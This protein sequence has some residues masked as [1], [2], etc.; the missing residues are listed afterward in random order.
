MEKHASFISTLIVASVIS[1][2][3]LAQGT[4]GFQGGRIPSEI[5]LG[6]PLNLSDPLVRQAFQ[7]SNIEYGQGSSQVF[8]SYVPKDK[9]ELGDDATV[10]Y[11][12]VVEKGIVKGTVMTINIANRPYREKLKIAANLF[13]LHVTLYRG[14]YG[15]VPPVEILRS[16]NL[17]LAERTLGK[18]ASEAQKVILA[19]GSA[20]ANSTARVIFVD[21]RR[22]R[23][24]HF[25][26]TVSPMQGQVAFLHS[27]RLID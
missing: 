5:E 27:E 9:L 7:I 2:H 4:M 20:V 13:E 10:K 1:F 14:I 22:T 25:T 26:V 19:L 3:A 6:V 23:L 24:N 18:N 11:D 8:F 12:G 16:D 15:S 21:G 17:L